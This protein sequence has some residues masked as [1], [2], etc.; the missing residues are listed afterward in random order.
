MQKALEESK[1]M[2]IEQE[3]KKKAAVMKKATDQIYGIFDGA[4][5]KGQ[6]KGRLDELYKE[7]PETFMEE[8]IKSFEEKAQMTKGKKNVKM[9]IE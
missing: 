6:I 4:F 8:G 7:S 2:A 5:T 1:K 9:D 3:K